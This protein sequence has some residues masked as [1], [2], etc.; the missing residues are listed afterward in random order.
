MFRGSR[1]HYSMLFLRQVTSDPWPQ[2]EHV[3]KRCSLIQVTIW[4]LTSIWE[5][6]TIVVDFVDKK[7]EQDIVSKYY[8]QKRDIQNKCLLFE[9]SSVQYTQSRQ[10]SQQMRNAD[11]YDTQSKCNYLEY[12]WYQV[13]STRREVF[14]DLTNANIVIQALPRNPFRVFFHC[15]SHVQTL[16]D[17]VEHHYI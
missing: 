10:P 2:Y 4:P 3:Q 8:T 1:E 5:T 14:S 9:V 15:M 16:L 13:P 12:A 6:L 11:L 7:C 17:P